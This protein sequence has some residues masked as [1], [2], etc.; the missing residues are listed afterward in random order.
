MVAAALAELAAAAAA[1]ERERVFGKLVSHFRVSNKTHTRTDERTGAVCECVCACVRTAGQGF[2]VR[3]GWSDV[4]EHL[5]EY[6]NLWSAPC[7]IFFNGS[8][9]CRCGCCSMMVACVRVCVLVR[10]A[11]A[12]SIQS[13]N[14][15]RHENCPIMWPAC[16]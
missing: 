10:L 14:L 8:Q 11:F 7:N 16:N 9:Y 3:R 2:S 5:R 15:K 1:A 12:R 4:S 6:Y 13:I